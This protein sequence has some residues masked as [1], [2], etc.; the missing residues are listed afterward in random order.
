[1]AYTLLTATEINRAG[2]AWPSGTAGVAGGHCFANTGREFVRV[3]APAAGGT[4][5][6]NTPG[7]KDGLDIEDLAVTFTASQVKAIGPFPPNLYNQPAGSS[8]AGRVLVDYGGTAGDWTIEV[9]KL[10]P[11]GW[12]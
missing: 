6:I 10:A 11:T 2:V 12:V 5:T 3:T 4:L 1:M 9:L 8:D 7:Q